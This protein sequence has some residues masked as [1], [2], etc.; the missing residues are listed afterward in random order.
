MEPDMI[1]RLLLI[2]KL[3]VILLIA[4]C[5]IRSG[6]VEANVD[7]WNCISDSLFCLYE[8]QMKIG[9]RCNV[10]TGKYCRELASITEIVTGPYDTVRGLNLA[11]GIPRDLLC[12][13][14]N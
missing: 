14:K 6:P 1:Q 4:A 5:S 12:K 2:P 10:V 3:K 9:G 8:C 13:R 11:D 7:R